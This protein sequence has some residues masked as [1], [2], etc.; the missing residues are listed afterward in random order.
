MALTTNDCQNIFKNKIKLS[1]R[2]IE[3]FT[4]PWHYATSSQLFDYYGGPCFWM[5][6]RRILMD[7]I[8]HAFSIV[9]QL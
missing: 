9:L 8:L 7:E 6:E 3:N 4:L 1:W 2:I 5:D